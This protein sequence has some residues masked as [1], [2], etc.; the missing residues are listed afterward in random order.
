MNKNFGRKTKITIGKMTFNSEDLEIQFEVPFDDDIKPNKSTIEIYNLSKSTISHIKK[1]ESLNVQAGYASGSV[2]VLASGKISK[3]LTKSENVD[4]ITVITM[5]EGE[6]FT[7]IKL[8]SNSADPAEKYKDQ[9]G[10]N[11]GKTKKQSMVINFK[12][13]TDGKTIIKRLVDALG[14][15]LD[16]PI[17]LIRNKVYK[18]GYSVTGLIMNNLEEV[19]RDCGSVMYH[20]RG[21]LVIRPLTKGT[22]EKFLLEE[23]TGLIGSPEPF[24]DT[25]GVKGFKVKCLL[26]HKITTASII[27]VKSKTA[28]GTF[29]VRRGEHIKDA[30]EFITEFEMIGSG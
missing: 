12:N 29:R 16:G 19:V 11:K 24:E 25:D 20:R 10:K 18:K 30:S 23:D 6:D 27:K 5:I 26:N 13:N 17:E 8:D 14:I 7:Q 1:G 28:N 21:K 2:G 9:S 4:K 22:D 3:A 15:K